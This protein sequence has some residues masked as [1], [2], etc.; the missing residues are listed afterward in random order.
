VRPRVAQ[1]G[2]TW[3]LYLDVARRVAQVIGGHCLPPDHSA[4]PSSWG[5]AEVVGEVAPAPAL[6]TAAVDD[7]FLST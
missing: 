3:E 1:P 4:D 2:V 5:S 7:E 6:L